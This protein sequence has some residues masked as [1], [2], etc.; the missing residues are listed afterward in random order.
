MICES[1]EDKA[2]TVSASAIS[3]Q[4]RYKE[5]DKNLKQGRRVVHN[6]VQGIGCQHNSRYN[7][8]D[9]CLDGKKNNLDE[10]EGE[11]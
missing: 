4:M 5:R 9:G 8:L 11:S 2:Q 6:I 10:L 1:V 3:N 7:Y